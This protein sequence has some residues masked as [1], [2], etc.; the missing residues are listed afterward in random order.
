[1]AFDAPALLAARRRAGGQ[2]APIEFAARVSDASGFTR[3]F[4]A[5]GG[6]VWTFC[7][8]F[9]L[10][11]TGS[12]FTVS[13]R[14]FSADFPDANYDEAF[15]NHSGTVNPERLSI[16]GGSSGEY[17]PPSGT[18]KLR[19]VNAW[20]PM[21]WRQKSDRAQ[22]WLGR[23]L[24]TD[25]AAQVHA[26]VNGAVKHALGFLQSPTQGK[27]LAIANTWFADGEYLDV[28]A[29]YNEYGA[30][31][32][33]DTQGWGP[34]SFHL[35]FAD[36]LDLGK[37]VLNSNDFAVNGTVTQISDTPTKQRS[38][39]TQA[40]LDTDFSTLNFARQI[41][42]TSSGQGSGRSTLLIPSGK[43]I[44]FETKLIF[45]SNALGLCLTRSRSA[46]SDPIEA[47]ADR[48]RIRATEKFDIGS[49]T[50]DPYGAGFAV[51]DII[52]FAI[53][54]TNPAAGSIRCYRNNVDLGVAF[55]N[56]L[57][58]DGFV[59][60]VEETGNSAR[61]DV[62]LFTA[63][64]DFTYTPPAGFEALSS[65][66]SAQAD[67]GCDHAAVANW[68][69]NS[70]AQSV[71]G[72]GFQPALLIAK[73]E[74][75]A[76][77]WRWM[78]APRGALDGTIDKGLASNDTSGGSVD[79]C[80]VTATS[81]G[82]DFGPIGTGGAW[83]PNQS[84]S[85]Y[86]GLFLRADQAVSGTTGG[87]GTGQSYTGQAGLAVSII[88]YEGNGVAGHRIPHHL[89]DAPDLVIVKRVDAAD[90]WPVWHKFLS[91]NSNVQYLNGLGAEGA[92]STV[93][94]GTPPD[95]N[96]VILGGSA[97]SNAIG[98]SYVMYCF[99][100]VPGVFHV[101]E[102]TGNGSSAGPHVPVFGHMPWYCIKG[103]TVG[104][105]DW[106]VYNDGIEPFRPQSVAYQYNRANAAAAGGTMW[107]F[108]NA[109]K[110]SNTVL[111]LN[112]SGHRYLLWGPIDI[113]AHNSPKSIPISR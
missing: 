84:G 15:L 98:G 26:R 8:W 103:I 34:N 59:F 22:L 1:M 6:R 58:E 105:T 79:S 82:V 43:K 5:D 90:D 36:E 101:G 53:D 24:Y 60:S 33:P 27:S 28:D 83:Y 93:F 68:T 69:G 44:Y 94:D 38:I 110:V 21:L 55:S 87:V 23:Q 89:A 40:S 71:T 48:Y 17:G 19:D 102:Y 97:R 91:S 106:G 62:D 99:R 66:V 12:Q 35:D 32:V 113:P 29:F 104:G 80:G 109:L 67:V 64:E 52:A 2:V 77:W 50:G 76:E 72:I 31:I 56:M 30:P 9:R 47:T 10:F 108:A 18:Q 88:A 16:Y 7:T 85:N 70:A 95:A 96:D 111:S 14:I 11:D 41:S 100:S 78:D 65:A 37:D 112:S 13:A 73:S 92:D 49:T 63:D 42:T 39:F 4:T 107:P 86:N 25:V 51:N 54:T 20:Y 46:A 74:N 75:V 45:V 81:N 61:V 3:T 57:V